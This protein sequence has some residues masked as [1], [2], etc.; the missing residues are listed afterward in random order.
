MELIE[1]GKT[2]LLILLD[3]EDKRKYSIM[4]ED[5]FSAMMDCY[6]R[7]ILDGGA[8]RSFLKG[9][10]VQI[11]DSE[12]GGLQMFVTKLADA[13]TAET[14]KIYIYIFSFLDELLSACRY[15]C[16]KSTAG[17]CAY[18]DSDR[19]KY[20]LTL[21]REY[22]QLCEFGALRCRD[23][24]EEYLFEHCKRFSADAVSTLGKLG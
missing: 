14:D 11:F 8:D 7:L 3:G 1:I 12:N 5:S 6:Y 16:E 18:Y 10:S 23:F 19:K 20:Y 24:T 21:E 9:T 2:Q 17:G 15:L 4:N 22:S 13:R